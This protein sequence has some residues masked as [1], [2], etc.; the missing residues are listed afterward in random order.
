MAHWAREC[1]QRD[2]TKPVPQYH[3]REK[4]NDKY[5][6]FKKRFTS[7]LDKTRHQRPWLT[8]KPRN[9]GTYLIDSI[10]PEEIPGEVQHADDNAIDDELEKI[11]DELEQEQCYE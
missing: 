4:S 8:D 9:Q 6:T 1:P 7:L 2:P 5:G 3:K 10:D 11:F